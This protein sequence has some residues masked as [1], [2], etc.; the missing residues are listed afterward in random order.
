[1]GLD[2]HKYSKLIGIALAASLVVGCSDNAAFKKAEK[3]YKDMTEAEQAVELDRYVAAFN[4]ISQKSANFNVQHH[5]DSKT[6]IIYAVGTYP[7]RVSAKELRQVKST[8]KK[9]KAA[10]NICARQE[11]IALTDLGIGFQATMKDLSGKTLYKS[12]VCRGAS[13]TAPEKTKTE[14][15]LRGWY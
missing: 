8:L 10:E 4:D 14:H 6:D 15:K 5:G 12:D 2:M 1:M 3:P 13:S 7:K 11:M 9:I